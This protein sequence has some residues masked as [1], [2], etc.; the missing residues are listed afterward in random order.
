MDEWKVRAEMM[1]TWGKDG[2]FRW[3]MYDD[4]TGKL[5][6]DNDGLGYGS[7]FSAYEGWYEKLRE[8]DAKK[9]IMRRKRLVH[10]W[11]E[12]KH[13]IYRLSEDAETKKLNAGY[14]RRLLDRMLIEEETLPF[15]CSDLSHWWNA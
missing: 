8:D 5:L 11:I 4:D 6:D 15:S 10:E 9:E 1:K 7:R 2:S 3:A 14:F 13:L 12:E